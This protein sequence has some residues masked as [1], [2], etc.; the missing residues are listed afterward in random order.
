M[1][2][3]GHLDFILAALFIAE[4]RQQFSFLSLPFQTQCFVSSLFSWLDNGACSLLR[5]D[6]SLR[7]PA[8]LLYYVP[9]Q[10][11]PGII[12]NHKMQ[13]INTC[14]LQ[15]V[16]NLVWFTH[17][18]CIPIT[19]S[20]CGMFQRFS[21]CIIKLKLCWHKKHIY[22][23]V[24]ICSFIHIMAVKLQ[25]TLVCMSPCLFHFCQTLLAPLLYLAWHSHSNS[26][27]QHVCH[28]ITVQI[29]CLR[30][31]GVPNVPSSYS[32]SCSCY[33]ER[34]RFHIFGRIHSHTVRY[35]AYI[36]IS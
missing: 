20:Q 12:S 13:H 18:S 36:Y 23:Y 7:H 5:C 27:S 8:H 31:I 16:R 11:T 17:L 2:H 26:F 3:S 15:N 9:H 33:R 6:L 1:W 28:Q 14:K 32:S 24:S 25:L 19:V 22:Q 21:M 10:H 35:T 29:R 4:L 30:K 34:C